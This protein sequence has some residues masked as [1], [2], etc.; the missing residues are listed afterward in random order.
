MPLNWF[1]VSACLLVAIMLPDCALP[2]EK[3][4]LPFDAAIP[5]PIL[6]RTANAVLVLIFLILGSPGR[7][8]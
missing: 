5:F 1:E 4:S 3:T 8:P 6:H 2:H 7:P